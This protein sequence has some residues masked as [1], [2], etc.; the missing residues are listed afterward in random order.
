MCT[1][2]GLSQAP[3]AH[4]QFNNNAA[5]FCC[6]NMFWPKHLTPSFAV[7]CVDVVAFKSVDLVTTEHQNVM[8][9]SASVDSKVIVSSKRSVILT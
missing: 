8:T 3:Q 6:V 7:S 1:S 9:D 5:I 2:V 4:V